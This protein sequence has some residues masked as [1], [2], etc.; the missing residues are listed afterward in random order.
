LLPLTPHTLHPAFE[1]GTD[2][3]FRNV[4]QLQLD[5]GEIPKR[6]YIRI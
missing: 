3:G 2:R 1:D 6:K 4:G 5:A